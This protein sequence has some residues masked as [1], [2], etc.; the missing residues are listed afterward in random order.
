MLLVYIKKI[1][2]LSALNSKEDD[3]IA[4]FCAESYHLTIFLG[5]KLNETVIEIDEQHKLS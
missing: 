3:L 1:L 5:K 2:K 4:N